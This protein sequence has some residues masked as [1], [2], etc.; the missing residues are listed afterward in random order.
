MLFTDIE[1]STRLLRQLRDDYGVVLADHHRILRAAFDAHEGSEIG[2]QGDALFV[3]FT[4][5]RSAAEAAV[6]AQR[7]LAAHDWPDGV[8]L[9]VRMGMHTGEPSVGEAGWHGIVLHRC[10]RIAASAQGGQ[11]LVSSATA[12][13]LHDDLP[14]GCELIELGERQ[15]KDFDRPER[16]YQLAAEGLLTEFPKLA[17]PKPAPRPRRAAQELIGRDDERE[18]IDEVLDDAR[19]SRSRA[20]VI[21][22]EAGV[23]KSAL[24]LHAVEQA[25]G[26]RVLRATGFESDSDL[27][28]SGLLQLLRPLLDRLDEL[29]EHQANALAG[30]LGLKPGQEVERLQ[31]G[32]A[33]LGLLALAAEDDDIL[34]AVDDAQ[35]LD[36]ASND[37]ILFASRRLEADRV[38]VV[39]TV[40]EGEVDYATP[41]LEELRLE[42]LSP[43][44]TGLLLAAHA[45]TELAP[46]VADRLY[47]LTNGNPLALVE[48]PRV[49]SEEQLHGAEPFEQ[50]LNLGSRVERV[51]R[52]RMEV[53]G[54]DAQR[55]LLIASASDSDALDSIVGALAVAGINASALQEAEDA[56]L[57][58][59]VEQSLLF[60]HPLA[61]SAVYHSAAPS[62]RRAVHTALANAL[63]GPRDVERR[64]WQLASAALGPD[65]EVAVALE[66]AA[67]AARERA[68]YGGASAAYERAARLSPDLD[69]R[70]RRLLAAGD[71]AWNAGQTPRAVAL[72]EEGLADCREPLIRGR[73][74]NARA[75]IERHAGDARIAYPWFIE[76]AELL[77]D[78]APVDA[79]AARIGAWRASL[80]AGNGQALAVAQALMDH[81]EQ[82]GGIQEFFAC[83]A[84]SAQDPDPD[85]RRELLHRANELV[86]EH[87]DEVFAPAPR[88]VSLA[89]MAATSVESGM[90]ICAWAVDWARE[91]GV[92]GALPASLTRRS[93]F[94]RRLEQ[95]STAYATLSEAVMI[96]SEQ[97][98][99]HFLRG[100]LVDLAEY[101][102]LRG[103][104]AACRAHLEEA[105]A[106]A[107]VVGGA[108]SQY[109]QE[110]LGLLALS[111][112]R[113]E[114]AIAA[115]EP[116]VLGRT[117]D[118]VGYDRPGAPPVRSEWLIPNLL[119]AYLR[120]GRRKDAE[121][122][123]GPRE[124]YTSRLSANRSGANTARCRGLLAADDSFDPHFEE[125][126]EKHVLARESF[127]GA[128]TRL[129]Y[130]ERLRRA[131]RRRDARDQLRPALDL[132]ERFGAAPWAERTRA[133]LR[134]TG[135]RLRPR[136]EA[137][138]ELTAQE[139][140][141]ALQA[142][143]GKTNRQIGATM[144]LSP[145]TVEFHLGRAYRK[146]GITSRAELIRHF[147]SGQPAPEPVPS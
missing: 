21:R 86:E 88:L 26:F 121:R 50:P 138:E 76:A 53:L 1:G 64:A 110:T 75:H 4:R 128:R 105:E 18:L 52:G 45:T 5:V 47:E 70:V 59:L 13:I 115:Y 102:A 23:G 16:V 100:A 133:E 49:L 41:G 10:A 37:A 20:L 107:A 17:S 91:R 3:A 33:T 51:F 145:K 98:T 127:D 15:L 117:Y 77:D 94:E 141:I 24:L 129:C 65:E 71:A 84:L 114:A 118:D 137:R 136:D 124:A 93:S 139:L 66:E 142:A 72:L 79:A 96:A 126:I 101:E 113:Y 25:E 38:A 46:G 111:L 135:E 12:E 7:A 32:V 87:G 108:G 146:L 116:L 125:A 85:R 122:L 27:A 40:R 67:D 42:G 14:L 147:V 83:L 112:G 73:L 106:L 103:E 132:F 31:I 54:A 62:E 109:E 2:T 30:A 57:I 22:G 63:T 55:A 28:F 43:E 68:G 29:P 44:A 99:R 123:L 140:R 134:A 56:G 9:R 89:G 6:E 39:L 58:S 143:E 74:L 82:D 35:W 90:R 34:I 144:F 78:V 120:V 130:G 92:Y 36:S 11:V 48:L 81:A 80:L 19:D 60:R 119:E 69:S 97:G 104:E 61:R 131:Q 8:E 95:W